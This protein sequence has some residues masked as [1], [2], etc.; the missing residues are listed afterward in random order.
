[1]TPRTKLTELVR[2]FC[3]KYPDIPHLTLAR[4]F[5]TKYP[6]TFKTANSARYAIQRARG[7]RKSNN[8][9]YAAKTIS[10][11][12]KYTG[13]K[14]TTN[15]RFLVPP[16]DADD[17]EDFVIHGAQRVLRLSDIHYPFHDVRALDAAINY[18]VN[19]DPTVLLLAGDIVDLPDFSKHPKLNRRSFLERE[20]TIVVQ[21]LDQFRQAFP[22]ARIVWMEGNH[23]QRLKKYVIEKA[24]ELAGVP[25]MDVPG[26][27]RLYGGPSAMDRVEWVDDCRTVRTGNLAHLHGHEFRGGGGVNPARWLYLRTGESAMVGHF[28]RTSEHSEPTLGGKQI[29]SWSTGCLCT[30]NPDWMRKTKWNHGMAYIEVEASGNFEAR[31]HRIIDGKVR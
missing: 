22:K 12:V 5:V 4:M 9:P 3:G 31:N 7:A 21:Q 28:H 16:S 25:L 15:F 19:L 14:G 1:M 8:N 2:E 29:G 23:E 17:Y 11:P 10:D 18:G 30:L 26:F 13:P 20:M 24:P 27:V 6:D